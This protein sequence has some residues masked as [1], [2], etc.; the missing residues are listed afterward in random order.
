MGPRFE[1]LDDPNAPGGVI[2]L[3]PPP[4]LEEETPST[5]PDNG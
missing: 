5:Q 3:L 2:E 1:G 4:P